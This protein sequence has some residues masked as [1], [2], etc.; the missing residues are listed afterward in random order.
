MVGGDAST[1]YPA[2][3]FAR[4]ATGCHPT[5]SDRLSDI[6]IFHSQLTTH[7]SQFTTHT[8]RRSL[9]LFH[10]RPR[11]ESRGNSIPGLGASF[12]LKFLLR[13]SLRLRLFSFR[14]VSAVEP[15][16][17]TFHS[18]LFTNKPQ[19]CECQQSIHSKDQ[20]SK[21]KAIEKL[22]GIRI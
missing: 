2:S 14:L 21:S 22:H 17:F 5:A 4:S 15:S 19:S 8:L 18:S 7:N 11:L 16:L 12:S 9:R 1:T 10:E 3:L 20:K 6:L 13:L